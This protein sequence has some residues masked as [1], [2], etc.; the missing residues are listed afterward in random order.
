MLRDLFPRRHRH[1]EDSPFAGELEAFAKWLR[2]IG[3]SKSSTNR[4]LCR[5]DQALTHCNAAQPGG[6]FKEVDLQE[7]FA[8]QQS[9]EPDRGEVAPFV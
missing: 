3:Y 4:H 2:T 9:S 6:T 7:A 8:S 1:Y 5:L